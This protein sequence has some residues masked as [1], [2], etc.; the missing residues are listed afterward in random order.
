[1]RTQ[2]KTKTKNFYFV[3]NIV[4]EEINRFENFQ[5]NTICTMAFKKQLLVYLGYPPS[6]HPTNQT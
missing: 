2:Q 5:E 4:N 1:M 3:E 6:I